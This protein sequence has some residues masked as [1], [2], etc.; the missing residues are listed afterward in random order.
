MSCGLVQQTK[1]SK[2]TAGKLFRLGKVVFQVPLSHRF[3]SI[4]PGL[5]SA[6]SESLQ[7]VVEFP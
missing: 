1:L 4:L 6:H 3:A 5:P 7:K 2:L